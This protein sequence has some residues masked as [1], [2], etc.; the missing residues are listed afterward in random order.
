VLTVQR[1]LLH[2]GKQ[3]NEGMPKSAAGQRRVELHRLA[4]DA[5]HRH[6][7]RQLEQRLA[8]GGE[9]ERP[10]LV[11]TT[12]RGKPQRATIITSYYLPRL[13]SRAG[14][15]KTTFHELRHS[16][17]TLMLSRGESINVGSEMVGHSN[18]AMTLGVYRHV[19]PNEQRAAVERLGDVLAGDDSLA[20]DLTANGAQD[21]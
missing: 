12:D 11:F 4:V 20:A 19:L 10:D 3:L 16:M 5:P 9:W 18:V 6:R 17:I 2:L 13:L 7:A 1:K 15:P 21:N 14:L 8:A